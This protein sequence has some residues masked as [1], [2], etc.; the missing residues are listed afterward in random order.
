MTKI[1]ILDPRRLTEA[2]IDNIRTCFGSLEYFSQNYEFIKKSFEENFPDDWHDVT[3][4]M[5][6]QQVY[7]AEELE[8][9]GLSHQTITVR[10]HGFSTK[11]FFFKSSL[12]IDLDELKTNLMAFNSSIQFRD[13]TKITVGTP[14]FAMRT[15]LP[16]DFKS[17]HTLESLG[18]CDQCHVYFY[19]KPTTTVGWKEGDDDSPNRYGDELRTTTQEQ[20]RIVKHQIIRRT[21]EFKSPKFMSFSEMDTVSNAKRVCFRS[22]SDDSNVL[23]ISQRLA[24]AKRNHEN[25]ERDLLEFYQRDRRSKRFSGRK[26]KCYA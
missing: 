11:P 15:L 13:V 25:A 8:S 20:V 14:P 19:M 24:D 5:V 21:V 2:E 7:S 6:F 18:F 10:I 22:S 9:V 16:R 26:R 17:E 23:E 12:Q 1:S 3:V 4:D